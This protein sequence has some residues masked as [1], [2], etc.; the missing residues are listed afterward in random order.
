MQWLI[1]YV[2]YG[3]GLPLILLVTALV[4]YYTLKHNVMQ[5]EDQCWVDGCFCNF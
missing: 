1:V 3:Y 5:P 2:C 4:L